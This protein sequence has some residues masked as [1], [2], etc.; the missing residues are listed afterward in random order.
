MAKSKATT[1]RFRAPVS[2]KSRWIRLTACIVCMVATANIQYAW[3]LF[4]PEIQHAYGWSR[5][6]IQLAFTIFVVV[7]TWL[8][9]LEGY[10]ID[11]YRAAPHRRPR[12]PVRRRRLDRRCARH[13]PDRLLYRRGDRRHRR[14]RHLR[15]LHQQCAALVSRPP[16]AGGGLDGGRLRRRFGAHHP[17]DR[18]HDRL[19][20]LSSTPSWCSASCKAWR[21]LSPPGFCARPGPAKSMPRCGWR[22]PPATT[23]SGKPC[24]RGCSG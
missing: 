17:A 2:D 7:Q 3:A 20:R 18:G 10:F 11:K 5:A 21:P 12:R 24:A 6:R 22:R 9:P 19:A 1:V 15:H 23:P 13:H 14:R 8:A 4:V 16:R